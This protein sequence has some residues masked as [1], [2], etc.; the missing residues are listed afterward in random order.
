MT[1]SVILS[2]ITV[3]YNNFEDINNMLSSLYRFNDIGEQLEVIV[4]DHSETSIIPQLQPLFPQAIFLE[5]ENKGFGSGNNYGAF[6]ARGEY[7]CFLNPDTILV[8]P[9]FA[10]IAKK[11]TVE[12]NIG[13]LGVQLTEQN[14][15]KNFSFYYIDRNSFISKQLIK[16]A[17]AKG[18][19]NEK[20]MYISGANL[21]VRRA[22][23]FECG[24]FDENM[25]M[26]YEEPDITKRI[27]ALGYTSYFMH[28]LHVIH[29]EGKSKTDTTAVTKRKYASAKYYCQKYDLNYYKILKQDLIYNYLKYIIANIR[30]NSTIVGLDEKCKYIKKLLENEK[31]NRE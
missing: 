21:F 16:I 9:I 23:F 24:A 8:E 14:L 1:S 18:K 22:L 29:L 20:T 6:R 10:K 17:N 4:V 3:V 7:L 25:F 26:Y 5:H 28:D 30:R 31:E 11:F 2:I 19:F 13:I 15:N 12:Q 27:W